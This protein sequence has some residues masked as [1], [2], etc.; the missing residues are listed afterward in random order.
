[1]QPECLAN[2]FYRLE[3]IDKELSAFHMIN[4][5]HHGLCGGPIADLNVAD[6]S[7]L[8]TCW[9]FDCPIFWKAL[10]LRQN[11]CQVRT[12]LISALRA[13]GASL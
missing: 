5:N 3:A 9:S 8:E 4:A 2:L 6:V 1:M 12:S 13:L 10:S 11:E 7:K